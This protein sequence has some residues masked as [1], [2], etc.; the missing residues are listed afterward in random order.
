MLLTRGKTKARNVLQ[1]VEDS[2]ISCRTLHDPQTKSDLIVSTLHINEMQIEGIH[3][4]GFAAVH[5]P[6][7]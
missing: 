6:T 5:P 2:E 4:I 1:L 3:H 7:C